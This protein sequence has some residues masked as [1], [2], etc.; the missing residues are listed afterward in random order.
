MHRAASPGAAVFRISSQVCTGNAGALTVNCS[1]SMIMYNAA[2]A[3]QGTLHSGQGNITAVLMLRYMSQGLPHAC[4]WCP[5]NGCNQK[6]A[7]RSPH[8]AVPA[9]CQALPQVI[10]HRMQ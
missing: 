9:R 4:V 3:S 6:D 7:K 2:A 1:S 8:L 5:H 10:C